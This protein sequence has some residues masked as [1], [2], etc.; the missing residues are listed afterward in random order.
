MLCS[1]CG[2]DAAGPS[3]DNDMVLSAEQQAALHEALSGTGALSGLGTYTDL[4]LGQMGVVGSMNVE[5]GL[6]GGPAPTAA[7]GPFA[8]TSFGVVGLQVKLFLTVNRVRFNITYTG[9]VAWTGLDVTARTV[10]EAISVLAFGDL[11]SGTVNLGQVDEQ[12]QSGGL[13]AV[14]LRPDTTVYGARDG[15]FTLTEMSFDPAGACT[16]AIGAASNCTLATGRMS[17]SFEFNASA[18]DVDGKIARSG[19]FEGVPSVSIS[20][21]Q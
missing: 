6:P 17:G 5:Q 3:N 15:S 10:D 21:F 1:G 12:F 19:S 18:A 14:V 7:R 20:V 2:G 13:A 4:V 11:E 16:G 8:T 9:L